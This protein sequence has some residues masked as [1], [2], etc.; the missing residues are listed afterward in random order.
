MRPS[1]YYAASVLGN[2][3]IGVQI[4]SPNA[5]TGSMEV[6]FAGKK[7]TLRVLINSSA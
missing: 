2:T 4:E 6:Q 1:T 5:L 3:P 7:R